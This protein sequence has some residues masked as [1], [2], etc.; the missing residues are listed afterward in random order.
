LKNE[1]A[2]VN[3]VEVKGYIFDLFAADA[4]AIADVPQAKPD[5]ARR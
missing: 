4:E 3:G 2:L 1:V 5:R